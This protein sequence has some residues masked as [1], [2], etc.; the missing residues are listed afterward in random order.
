M[1]V[2]GFGLLEI[3]GPRLEIGLHDPERFLD[4]PEAVIG[5]VDVQSRLINFGGDQEVVAGERHVLVDF[6][7]V[8]RGAHL[9]DLA[10]FVRGGEIDVFRGIAVIGFR[11]LPDRRDLIGLVDLLLD[12][13]HLLSGQARIVGDHPFLPRFERHGLA[14]VVREMVFEVVDAF[15]VFEDQPAVPVFDLGPL[16]GA[17]V[18]EEDPFFLLGGEALAVDRFR[19]DVSV[20]RLYGGGVYVPGA[21]QSLVGDLDYLGVY[22]EP[23]F[24]IVD[25]FPDLGLLGLVPGVQRHADR[26]LLLVQKQRLADDRQVPFF[27]RGAHLPVVFRQADLEIVVC[28]VEK[29][30]FGFAREPLFNVMVHDLDEL[31]VVAPYEIDRVQYLAVAERLGAVQRWHH[32]LEGVVLGARVHDL[33]ANHREDEV[34]HPEMRVPASGH[35][36]DVAAQSEVVPDGLQKKMAEVPFEGDVADFLL[37]S[38]RDAFVQLVDHALGVFDRVGDPLF[39]QIAAV[40]DR[41]V[42]SVA[43]A[44]PRDVARLVDLKVQALLGRGGFFQEVSH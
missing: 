22:V 37:P 8:E 1:A 36:V 23:G 9:D 16:V 7:L 34:G 10:V 14:A 12:L 11:R 29:R 6:G 41:F 3:D 20:V 17:V 44:L 5:V 2:D 39:D 33:G 24:Q 32:L 25:G 27:L 19:E 35:D 42:G 43:G 28:A 13:R 21:V 40:A 15:L 31:L 18:G 26:D 38:V 4:P 30:L